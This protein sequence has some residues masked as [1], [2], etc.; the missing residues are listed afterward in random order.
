MVYTWLYKA[1]AAGGG[2]FVFRRFALAA[3][4]P[5]FADLGIV[6]DDAVGELPRYA[7]L[8]ALYAVEIFGVVESDTFFEPLCGDVP[9]VN[10]RLETLSCIIG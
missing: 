9:H 7:V 6:L 8:S 5:A 2:L 10:N 1:L 3:Q 4:L